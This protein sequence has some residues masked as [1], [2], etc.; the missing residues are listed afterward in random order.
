MAKNDNN[1]N[2]NNQLDEDVLEIRRV[3]RVMSGGKRFS[4]RAVV[5]V[6][7]RDGEVGVGMGKGKDVAKAIS[8]AKKQAKKNKI[9]TEL[10]EDRTI[11]YDIESK[12]GAAKVL[13]KPTREGHGLI[14]GGAVRSV[15]DLVGVEDI[16]AKILGG[17]SNKLNNARATVKAL[18]EFSS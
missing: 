3:T 5:G 8:K 16:S 6:G 2:Q 11:P 10:K 1:K 15:L 14:A 12:Y 9:E 4:F 17:S 18:K 7:N 13:L